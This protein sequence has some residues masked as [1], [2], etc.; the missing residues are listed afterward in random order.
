MLEDNISTELVDL[1]SEVL[2]LLLTSAGNVVWEDSQ[3]ASRAL[4]GLG[5]QPVALRSDYEEETPSLDTAETADG[6]TNSDHR[7][8]AEEE[9]VTTD[10]NQ[11][12]ESL[13]DRNSN[14]NTTNP[15]HHHQP[16]TQDQTQADAPSTP[17]EDDGV[18][19]KGHHQWRLGEAHP[20][21]KALLLRYAT[22]LDVK[23]KGAARSSTYYRKH[24]R[25]AVPT[26]SS[27]LGKEEGESEMEQKEDL[28]SVTKLHVEKDTSA[29][30][31]LR[32]A[33][34]SHIGRFSSFSGSFLW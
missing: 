8:Q 13:S 1:K 15:H 7:N 19:P 32:P 20:K 12:V 17:A 4:V 22:T 21:S 14:L 28:R 11:T 30:M 33:I 16:T 25:P 3:S 26:S 6:E 23:K 29:R 5:K 24:G 9:E 2:L 34:L 18:I 27:S 10:Q 31:Q